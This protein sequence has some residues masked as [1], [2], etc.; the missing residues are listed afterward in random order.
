MKIAHAGLV[1]ASEETADT[2]YQEV[3]GLTK[4]EPKILARPL[5]NAIFGVDA[6]LKMINYADDA[7]HFEIFIHDGEKK[8]PAIIEHLC[9]EVDDRTRFLDRCRACGVSVNSI[10]KGEKTIVFIRDFDGNLF[11]VK[12]K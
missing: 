3:L 11:E 12:E 8:H 1:C 2:F 9:I 7:S 6:E 5:S 10:P 4:Q